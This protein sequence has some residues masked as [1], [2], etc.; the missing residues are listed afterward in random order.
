M[1][2]EIGNS[3]ESWGI[4]GPS[5]LS[6]TTWSRCLDQIAEAGYQWLE[7][8]P[9]GYLPTDPSI[10]KRELS[11]RG[12]SISAGAILA[13]LEDEDSWPDIEKEA[14]RTGELLSSLGAK[15]IIVVDGFY[16]YET[17][18]DLAPTVL[19]KHKWNILID[20]S[21]KLGDLVKSKFGL[22]LAFHPCADTH[23][24]YEEQILALLS[25]TDPSLVTLC[26]D[27]GHHAYRF[28]DPVAFMKA[29]HERIGY[30]H[31]KSV[32]FG[33][34]DRVNKDDVAF[35]DAV[36][37]GVMCEPELGVVDFTGF[38]K[39]L[40]EIGFDGYATVEHDMYR[41]DLDVPFPIAKRTREYL[42][43]V[44]IG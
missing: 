31:L 24:Q 2:I 40:H 12:L 42:R 25:D 36:K 44:G 38:G 9:Y 30:L 26:L 33:I 6:Q 7:L 3:P 10:V 41:P 13:P 16:R 18:K 43:K 21:H 8:G 14:L 22:Q 37:L 11:Q 17:G 39:V 15:F 19:D 20:T 23:V 4:T 35:M 34:R 5:E 1:G 29:H 32:D 28:G 27:T